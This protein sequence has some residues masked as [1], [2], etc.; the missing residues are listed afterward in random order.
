MDDQN[1]QQMIELLLQVANEEKSNL[2]VVTHDSRIKSM[3]E[4]KVFLT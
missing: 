1:C 4:K 2:I 3:I